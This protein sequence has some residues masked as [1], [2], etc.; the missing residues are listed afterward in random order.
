[1]SFFKLVILHRYEI[2]TQLQNLNY[3]YCAF[4][5]FPP[6]NGVNSLKIMENIKLPVA[7]LTSKTGWSR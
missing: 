6:P 7:T 5:S 1:M 4:N 3:M 2:L